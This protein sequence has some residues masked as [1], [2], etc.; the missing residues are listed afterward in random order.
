MRYPVKVTPDDNGTFLVTFPDVP[1]ATFGATKAEALDHALDAL[2]TAFDGL[3]RDK[4]DIP[5]PSKV[6]GSTPFV[7]VP[8]LEE[9][10]IVLYQTMRD[11]R[12]SKAELG[13]RLKVHAP[14]VDRLLDVHHSTHLKNL[15][16]AFGAMG[17]GLELHI[18][19]LAPSK[20]QPA[21]RRRA[22]R[23]VHP[24]VLTAAASG[25]AKRVGRKK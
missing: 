7:T 24:G 23:D 25:L 10:K 12:V 17:A 15:T 5:P 16:A 14:Q 18:V 22:P 1:G 8:L 20:P 4:R 3:M 19:R 9:A 2:L 11:Q 21:V 6:S 13:R